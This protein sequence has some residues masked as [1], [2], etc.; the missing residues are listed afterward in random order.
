MKTLDYKDDLYNRLQDKDY[1]A[2]YLAEVLANEPYSTFLI[3][4]K[5]VVEARSAGISSLA[6]E[7]GVTRQALHKIMSESGNPR[8]STLNEL[9]HSIGL[10]ISV[11]GLKSKVA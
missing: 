1:A 5:D 11:T 2:A 7:I 6:D 3:A 9:L 10:Q 8:L 4:L